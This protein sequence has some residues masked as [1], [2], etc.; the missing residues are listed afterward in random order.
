MLSD[1][2]GTLDTDDEMPFVYIIKS[3]AEM[4]KADLTSQVD[5]EE[6][7]FTVPNVYVAGSLRVY[8]NGIRQESGNGFS[9]TTSTTFT[10]TFT[11]SV[12][13]TI[14]VDYEV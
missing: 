2:H 11:P 6:N 13:E 8:Y 5:G 1:K 10:T 9:E 4:K 12:G 3:G 14:S 7:V